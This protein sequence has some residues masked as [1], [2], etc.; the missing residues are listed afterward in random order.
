[1]LAHVDR[2]RFARR[3][4]DNQAIATLV[5]MPINQSPETRQIKSAI[6]EHG[7]YKSNKAASE[8]GDP[9][10]IKTPILSETGLN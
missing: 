9:N 5:D 3:T 1:M 10:P 6:G 4:N 8:H 2:W 7:G